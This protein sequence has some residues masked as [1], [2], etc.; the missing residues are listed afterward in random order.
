MKGD[1]PTGELTSDV[2]NTYGPADIAESLLFHHPELTSNDAADAATVMHEHIQSAPGLEELAEAIMDKG[3]AGWYELAPI[4]DEDGNQILTVSDQDGD[5]EADGEPMWRYDPLQ[6]VLDHAHTSCHN[7]LK[8][9]KND[10]TLKGKLWRTQEA[11]SHLDE[12]PAAQEDGQRGG[13]TFAMSNPGFQSGFRTTMSAQDDQVTLSFRNDY[14][15]HLSVFLEFYDE[16]W[17]PVTPDSWEAPTLVDLGTLLDLDDGHR[18]FATLVDP[19]PLLLGI[20]LPGDYTEKQAV[21]TWPGAARYAL[22][23]AG[24]LGFSGPGEFDVYVLGATM[25]GV[26]GIAFPTV[27]LGMQSG[28]SGLDL[29]PLW[30]DVG[31]VSAVLQFGISVLGS[32]SEFDLSNLAKKLAIAAGNFLWGNKKVREKILEKV[33]E[34]Y[35][36]EA[37]PFVG[38]ALV[39]LDM[40]STAAAL[41]QTSAEV[42]MSPLCIDNTLTVTHDV[43]IVIHHDPNDTQFPATATH[44]TVILR[45][46]SSVPRVATVPMPGTTQSD[47]LTVSFDDVPAGG[48]F[49]VEV[50]F[51]SD[52]GWVAGHALRSHVPNVNDPG[53]DHQSYD[54]TIEE[55]LVPL[56]ADTT[57]SHKERLTFDGT[58][59]VWEATTSGPTRTIADL[60]H[61]T[62]GTALSELVTLTLAHSVP[63]LGYVWKAFSSG[64]TPCPGEPS[65]GQ[66]YQYQTVST[67]QNPEDGYRVDACGTELPPFLSLDPTATALQGSHFIVAPKDGLWYVREVTLSQGGFEVSTGSYGS[68]PVYLDGFVRNTATGRMAGISKDYSKILVLDP[69]DAPVD[70][71]DAPQA[72]PLSGQALTQEGLASNP[73]LLANPI[74]M[75]MAPKDALM[76]LDDVHGITEGTDDRSVRGQLK[77]FSFDGTPIAY[78]GPEG[79][80]TNTL[81]LT[82]EDDN[83]EVHYLDFLMDLQDYVFVLSYSSPRNDATHKVTF[84]DY[85]LDIFMPDGS[86]LSRTTGVAAARIAMDPWRVLFTLNYESFAGPGGRTEPSV[87]EWIPSTPAGDGN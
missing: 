2:L 60:D 61:S 56:T 66:L 9:V 23:R 71:E 72:I 81:A 8:S 57:Y 32:S 77:A 37:I 86:W 18:R 13:Y 36:E 48:H 16:T 49:E 40:A 52:T 10:A 53:L 74:A 17:A 62:Q 35:C 63:V 87:S 28:E 6:E 22:V 26:F 64:E 44:Y 27:M 68:F 11:V 78:F 80:Q 83:V 51:H 59:H 39:A 19:V 45:P 70:D 55:Q 29:S 25:T 58:H 33:A 21:F 67:A 3:P 73:T 15:R 47:P 12:D 41:I 34:N 46:G 31:L 50:V 24:G 38:W 76:V 65:F 30:K 20:P 7:A 82:E 69:P 1:D 85:R 43:D 54:I 42:A 4:T 14:V 5:G 75:R 84:E 79:S